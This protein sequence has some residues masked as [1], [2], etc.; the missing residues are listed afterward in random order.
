MCSCTAN[1]NG[2][3]GT[4]QQSGPGSQPELGAD[5]KTL[6]IT[7]ENITPDI[8]HAKIGAPGRWEVPKSIFLTPNVT[9]KRLVLISG[10]Y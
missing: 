1:G 2:L 7:V 10:Y 5:I 4:L 8:L 6:T 3:Q 9:G